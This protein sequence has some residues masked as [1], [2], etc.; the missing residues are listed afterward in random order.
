MTFLPKNYAM[1]KNGNGYYLKFEEG[2]NT[3]R[4]L[5]DA[6]VGWVYWEDD[7]GNV[8]DSPIKGCKAIHVK[9]VEE[10]PEAARKSP[11]LHLKHFWAFVVWSYRDEAVQILKLTQNSIMEAMTQ[12][13]QSAKWGNPTGYDFI[14]HKNGEGLETRYQ[15][16][17]NPKEPLDEGI[18]KMH[19]DMKVDLGA[20][21]KGEDPFKQPEAEKGNGVPQKAAAASR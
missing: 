13:I 14:I 3:F 8:L 18:V 15:V 11:R 5:S 21:Y 1:P 4:V 6:I 10:I 2:E 12:Y 7:Q 20:F 19:E 17:V 16:T 9:R